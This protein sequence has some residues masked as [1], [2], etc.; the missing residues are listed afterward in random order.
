MRIRHLALFACVAGLTGCAT[1]QPRS[2]SIVSAAS[3]ETFYVQ[4]APCGKRTYGR[5]GTGEAVVVM[6]CAVPID[7]GR[8]KLNVGVVNAS[9]KPVTL[10]D[11]G[12]TATVGGAPVRI[13]R[14][15]EMLAEE[16]RRQAWA[17][18]ALALS[19]GASGYAAAGAGD[20][21]TTGTYSGSYQAYGTRSGSETGIY[22]GTYTAR[23]YDPAAA[24]RAQAEVSARNAETAALLR[25]QADANRRQI[26]DMALRPHTVAPGE[27]IIGSV[28]V[29]LP[30]R[31]QSAEPMA[32]RIAVEDIT[33][34]FTL[35]VDN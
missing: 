33:A 14:Y 16:R 23:T 1:N 32:V 18:A 10:L 22:A 27:Q 35:L 24:Q 30:R 2:M 34:H 17:A 8:A 31:G 13:I 28:Y 26:E 3:V 19:A 21:T 15:Q 9:Q 20:T 11:T 25:D 29:E 4:G 12:V 7:G 6:L 5:G